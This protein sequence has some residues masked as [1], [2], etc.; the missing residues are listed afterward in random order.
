MRRLIRFLKR[1]RDR[2]DGSPA[3]EFAFV[4]PIMILLVVG[5]IE[6]GMIMFVTI[7]MESGLRDAARYGITGSEFGKMSRMERIVE[8]IND[9]TLG[10]VDISEADIQILVYPDFGQIGDGE[11][12]V[13]GNGNGTYD[14]GETFTD[15]NGNGTWDSD[16]GQSGPGASGQVVLYRIEYAWNLLTPLA[17]PLIGEGGKFTLSASI[18][19]RNEPYNNGGA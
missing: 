4:A 10:L 17:A 14:V 19:V 2:E 16:I 18:A 12:F 13:D 8:I 6:F 9:R 7:L 15:A 3:A 5:T 11:D 1:L